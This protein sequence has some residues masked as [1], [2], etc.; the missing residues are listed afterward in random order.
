MQPE[1][2]ARCAVG[3][4]GSPLENQ[5][6]YIDSGGTDRAARLTIQTGLHHPLGIQV[7]IVLG[8]DDLEP[9]A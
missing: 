8:R 2:P 7:A 1:H 3:M 5:I 6:R 4:L 9:S